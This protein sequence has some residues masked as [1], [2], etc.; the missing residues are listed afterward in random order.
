MTRKKNLGADSDDSKDLA[1]QTDS[2][3]RAGVQ[4]WE[5]F[6]TKWSLIFSVEHFGSVLG[7]ACWRARYQNK[8]VSLSRETCWQ[9]FN[10]YDKKVS[11]N[12]GFYAFHLLRILRIA[13]FSSR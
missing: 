13:F 10:T 9:P 7:L 11:G 12:V 4:I 2:L 6:L 3:Q 5:G 8:L 1:D